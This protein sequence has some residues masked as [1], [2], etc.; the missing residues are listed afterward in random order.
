MRSTTRRAALTLLG[1]LVLCTLLVRDA[2]SPPA[3]VPATAP[4]TDFSAERALRHVRQI[5]Q[6]PHPVGSAENA[7]IREYLV[8]ELRALGLAPEVQEATGVG[9]RYPEAGQVK[10]V[11]ARLPGRTPGGLAVVLMAHYDGVAGAPA[12][13]DDAAGTAAV[14]ETLRALEAGP[15]L[16]NDVIA[17]ITDGEEAGLLG[18]AAFV[19]EHPWAKDVGV[20]LN[21]EARGTRGRSYM[22]ETGPG[23]LDVVRVLSQV[24]DVSA[25]S[26]SVTVYRMLPND[27]DLSELAVLGRPALNF[28]FADGV[29]RYHTAHDDVAH[30]DPGSLQH[31]GSQA[32]ALAR[33]FGNGPLPRRTTGDAVFFDLPFIGL[34]VYPEPWTLPVGLAVAALVLVGVWRLSRRDDRWL[35]SIALGVLAT[36]IAALVAAVAARFTGDTFGRVH[37]AMG[38][39][40]APAFRGVYAAAIVA[41]ALAVS[42]ASYAAARRWATAPGLHAGALVTWSAITVLVSMRLPGV[43]FLFVWPLLAVG[44]ALHVAVHAPLRSRAEPGASLATDGSLWIATVIAAAILVP[45]I[46]AVSAVLLGAF[47]PGGIAA[48]VFTALLAWLL[49]PQM[50][51][52]AAGHAWRAAGLVLLSALALFGVGAATVRSSPEHPRG[53]T[54]VYAMDADAADAW[55]ITRGLQ[56]RANVR[57]DTLVPAP[58]W[59]TDIRTAGGSPTYAR[60]NRASVEPPSAVVLTDSA[61]GGSRQLTLRIRAAAGTGTVAMRVNGPRVLRASVDGRLVDTTRYRSPVRQWQLDYAAPPDTG[62]TIGLTLGSPVPLTLDLW[63]YTSGLPSMPGLEPPPR[64]PDVVTVQSGDVTIVRRTLRFD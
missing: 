58:T 2:A 52:L 22:F 11:L 36:V 23:N 45:V 54:V 38:W 43:S 35:R 30:L 50:E 29:E 49:A 44:V 6:R 62:F 14:L 12:A 16:A 51:A 27:T 39:G 17:L 32:L 9:T 4:A 48:A 63:A 13:S 53:S 55:L 31:H 1:L 20:A 34:V 24:P 57:A 41:L 37:A 60:M 59:V 10:N 18:A 42:V 56:A 7:R 21:F 3:P 61:V 40:G 5:A 46:Y 64:A 25:T 15:P 28:A 8:A 19:R 26:L 33:A 47:G